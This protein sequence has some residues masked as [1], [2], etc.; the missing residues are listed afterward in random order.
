[1]YLNREDVQEMLGVEA[2]YT[3]SM[4]NSDTNKRFN[5]GGDLLYPIVN[6]HIVAL[7]E[8]GIRVLVYVG[9]NDYICNQVCATVDFLDWT[10]IESC[11]SESSA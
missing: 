11:R 7:L 2:P 6:H 1:M 5:T 9:V 3:F 8:R 10:L 4:C